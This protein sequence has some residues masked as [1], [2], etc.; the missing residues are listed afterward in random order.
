[1]IQVAERFLNNDYILNLLNKVYMLIVGLFTTAFLTRYF[2]VALKGEYAF[3]MQ[4]VQISI[5]IFNFGVYQSYYFN[6]RKYGRE[7]FEKY[8]N[9]FKFQFLTYIIIAGIIFF[10][11]KKS[12]VLIIILLICTGIFRTQLEN[13]MLVENLRFKIKLN[14]IIKTIVMLI[15]YIVFFMAETFL[16]LPFV[17]SIFIDVIIIVAYLNH[18][19]SLRLE[20]NIDIS[21]LFEVI[22]FGIIPMFTSLLLVFNYSIDI[23]FL[24]YLGNVTDLGLYATAAG[25]VNYV[26]IIPDTFKDVLYSR[27]SNGEDSSSIVMAIRVSVITIIAI[28]IL[29]GLSGKFVLSILYGSDFVDAYGVVLILMIGAISMVFF[30]ITG[31][32]FLTEGRRYAYFFVLLTS[33][34]CNCVMNYYLIPYCGKYGAAFASVFSYSICGISFLLYFM[35]LKKL[36]PKSFIKFTESE[37]KIIRQLTNK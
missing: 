10:V 12:S 28:M 24:K 17:I 27:I 26:W 8:I 16:Y 29:F 33:A 7:I 21:F 2:G 6:F 3:L 36:K 4:I 30:K 9:I 19:N 23:V 31:V 34:I 14:I 11:E 22:R 5:L 37:A 1:M 35:K 18:T 25:I 20:F 15:Y 32:V 13:I